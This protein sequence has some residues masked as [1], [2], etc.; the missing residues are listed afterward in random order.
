MGS[1]IPSRERVYVLNLLIELQMVSIGE[2][3]VSVQTLQT[4]TQE[5]YELSIWI[6]RNMFIFPSELNNEENDE[7]EGPRDLQREIWPCRPLQSNE[8][9]VLVFP[10]LY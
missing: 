1:D 4:S 5:S 7:K 9:K 8:D 10:S 3:W 6:K 2:K